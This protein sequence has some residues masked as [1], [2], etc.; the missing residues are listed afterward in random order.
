VHILNL[1]GSI[2]GPDTALVEFAAIGCDNFDTRGARAKCQEG[3]DDYLLKVR[4][5]AYAST[6]FIDPDPLNKSPKV[7]HMIPLFEKRLES[8]EPYTIDVK[9]QRNKLVLQDSPFPW[10]QE[11]ESLYSTIDQVHRTDLYYLEA[12]DKEP[13]LQVLFTL[14]E[15]YVTFNRQA[16]GY[17]DMFGNIGGL[18]E[19]VIIGFSFLVTWQSS[20]LQQLALI[21]RTMRTR[22]KT[23]D[24]NP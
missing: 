7:T 22:K 18:A 21:K 5:T 20:S 13:L 1:A 11:K 2:G 6:T 4:I 8:D 19:V 17:L 24:S 23:S 12:A 9:I 14:D 10:V 15:E 16:F 3:I